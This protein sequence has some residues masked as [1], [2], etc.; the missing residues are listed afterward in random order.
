MSWS[1][2]TGGHV[3]AS[4]T[5][6][7]DYVDLHK[8]V[9]GDIT[10]DV[11][12]PSGAGN[13][14]SNN[15]YEIVQVITSS[16]TAGDTLSFAAVGRFSS[17]FGGQNKERALQPQYFRL[18]YSSSDSNGYRPFL[19]S[20]N[21]TASNGYGQYFLGSGQYNSFGASAELPAAASFIRIILTG[22][23]N[24][25]SGYSFEK[26]LFAKAAM[27]N[28]KNDD[29]L[30][31]KTFIN[32][33]SNTSNPEYPETEITFDNFRLRSNTRKV[34]LTQEGLLIYNSEDSFFKMSSD[35][36]EIQGGSGVSAFGSSINRET[37][38]N[39]SQV[40][41]TLG[42][43]ALQA[44]TSDP[45]D[46]STTAFQGNIGEFARGNHRHTLPFATVNSVVEGEN[47]T[48]LS[49]SSVHFAQIGSVDK[50]N[51]TQLTS[52]NMQVTGNVTGSSTS[53]G[54][55][56]NV[57][58][59]GMSN[60]NI[61]NVSSSLATRITNLVTDS[62]SFS[63]RITADSSSFSTRVTTAEV[64][65]ENRII[66]ASAQLSSEISGS[67]IAP[68]SSISTR[69]TAEESNIDTLQSRNLTAGTGLTG[70]GD[71]TSDRTFAVDFSDSTFK[72][73][74]SGSYRGDKVI[75]GSAQIATDISG[76]FTAP[77]ASFST[78]TAFLEGSG[79]IQ[80]LGTTNNVQFN[81]ITSNGNVSGSLTSTGSFGFVIA[82]STGSFGHILINGQ[83]LQA[84]TGTNTGDVTLTGSGGYITV[85][86]NQV[87]TVDTIDISD[88]TNLAGGVGISLNGDTL[89]IDFSDSTLKS[90]VT[91][92]FLPTSASFS[93]RLT[94]AESELSNTLISSSAQIAT[95]ISGSFVAPSASF[96]TRIT[97]EEANVDT[98]QAR[99]LI[100]GTG[101][102]G[103][104]TL[105]ADRTFNVVGGTG[106]TAN[107]N[108]I[109]VDF[110]DSVFKANVSGSFGNQRVGTTDTPTF[111]G[112]NVDGNIEAKQYIVSSSVSYITRSFSS[113]ST[114]FGDDP[115]DT[116]Q[117]TGSLRISGSDIHL[118]DGQNNIILGT[119]SSPAGDAITTG[120]FN[121]LLGGNNAG[122]AINS[123]AQNIGIG[124]SAL[125]QITT[126]DNNVAIGY[127]SG[128]GNT[129]ADHNISIGFQAGD[130]TGPGNVAIGK[131]TLSGNSNGEYNVA[132]GFDAGNDVTTGQDN[133]LIGKNTGD[134][135]TIGRYNV[136][137]GSQALNTEDVGN[138]STAIGYA[139]LSSQNSDSN[140][141]VT[142]NV[143]VGVS[144]GF[145][146][147]TGLGNT[148]IGAQSGQG[149]SNQSNS[150][151]TGVGYG[152]LFNITTGTDNA[153]FKIS[154]SYLGLWNSDTYLFESR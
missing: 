142:Y 109:E 13:Y 32:T 21:F 41:G 37:V 73:T 10:L 93:T 120:T 56:G 101:L 137:L 106:I 22:S 128:Q 27:G 72:S 139:A 111:A 146:N 68:S 47:F 145:Y 140:N 149:A 102:T 54:S 83:P 113:G 99:D 80:S 20:S 36:I 152:S 42:A 105:T 57:N 98:L 65:L 87:I 1:Y 94:T 147:V 81:N 18:E 61:V 6:R 151:N 127:N 25:D 104:G 117:F 71:L 89:D 8:A 125:E 43:P 44:Y 141:E 23:I 77:S 84:A 148:Y 9:S 7:A 126:G 39:D 153:V 130:L 79:E 2:A 76:S 91:G 50:A 138:S 34:E 30:G 14:S 49:A 133:V 74:I 33:F 45:E 108:D 114:I 135:I 31:T 97:T 19:P 53:T 70:G 48:S 17:S 78:R 90:A 12:V 100:A 144:A 85:G 75:S 88:D 82:E 121:I 124:G 66:S 46:V 35:G 129:G 15:T 63:T 60:T 103:G 38:T 67:F 119:T 154:L 110:E 52:S 16:F 122:G 3:T 143:G 107:A 136:A 115:A 5:D 86:S 96:S 40:A 132:I 24:D 11:V 95:D 28:F 92:S 150:R 64:E 4:L 26:P 51:I 131:G 123:G 112:L 134:S 62:G 116:H 29:E 55:F 58:I 118:N 69:L 59:G